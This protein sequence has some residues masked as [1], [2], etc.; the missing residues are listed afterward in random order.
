[1]ANVKTQSTAVSK[2][3]F[4]TEKNASGVEVQVINFA[5]AKDNEDV[6]AKIT[7]GNNG[8]L[9]LWD[10]SNVA[11]VNGNRT[12]VIDISPETVQLVQNSDLTGFYVRY[13]DKMSQRKCLL[14]A[15]VYN[16]LKAGGNF[17][18]LIQCQTKKEFKADLKILR[19]KEERTEREEKRLLRSHN[20]AMTIVSYVGKAPTSQDDKL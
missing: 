18:G 9:W 12:K 6:E 10:F 3:N 14:S 17:K 16:V 19:A 8:M 11:E 5:D 7:T 20:F 15:E 2:A 4:T 1:M 13:I